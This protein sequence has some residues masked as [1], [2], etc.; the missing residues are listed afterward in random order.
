[1]LARLPAPRRLQDAAPL[2]ARPLLR[3]PPARD[4][5][6]RLLQPPRP[7]AAPPRL[8]RAPVFSRDP[9]D[10]PCCLSVSGSLLS[11]SAPLSL[12]PCLSLSLPQGLWVSASLSPKAFDS[13]PVSLCDLSTSRSPEPLSLGEEGACLDPISASP[14]LCLFQGQAISVPPLVSRPGSLR[15][16]QPPGFSSGQPLCLPVRPCPSRAPLPLFLF[17]LALCLPHS[18]GPSPSLP[19]SY[20]PS[21]FPA[22]PLLRSSQ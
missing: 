18:Q 19:A 8:A 21:S 5:P 12:P 1:M 14:S 11:F 16:S 6:S 9:Q 13:L 10:H 3:G 17:S 7:Q 2:C 20:P 15:I 22:P 4:A